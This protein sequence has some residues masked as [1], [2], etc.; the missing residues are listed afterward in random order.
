MFRFAQLKLFLIV[1]QGCF[2]EGSKLLLCAALSA[3][4]FI[5][6]FVDKC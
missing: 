1:A 3:I 6:G 2:V 5:S 4:C